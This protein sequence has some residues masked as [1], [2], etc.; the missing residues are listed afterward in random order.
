[1][2]EWRETENGMASEGGVV[3]RHEEYWEDGAS[4]G[5]TLE[6][7][8]QHSAPVAITCGVYGWM[9]HTRYFGS[10]AA[11]EVAAEEM[12]PSLVDLVHVALSGDL[13]GD[14]FKAFVNRFPT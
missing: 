13:S 9:V 7:D 10:L 3:V 12:K 2:A 8:C 1:V 11:A 4:A 14:P 5:I 6:R